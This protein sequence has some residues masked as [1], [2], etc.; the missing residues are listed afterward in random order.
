MKRIIIFLVYVCFAAILSADSKPLA[1][2]NAKVYPMSGPTMD[3]AVVV[4]RDGKIEAIGSGLTAPA[5]ATIIDAKGGRVLPGFVDANCRVGLVEIDAVASTVD[6]SESVD[7]ITPQMRV[8]DAFYPDSATIGVA[9]SNGVTSGIIAP[10]HINVITGMSAWITFSGAS[11]NQVVLKPV[12]GMNITL[13]E[14]PKDTYGS[15]DKMPSTRMGTAA[16]LRENLQAAKEY[17]EK[18]KSYQN[19]QQEGSKKKPVAPPDKDFRLEALLDVVNG[20]VPLVAS[21]QRVDD[22]LTAIRIAEEFGMKQNL[23]INH[24]AEAYKIA[25]LL[26][27]EKIPVIVGPITTQPETMETLGVIY[28]NAALLQKAGVLIALQTNDAHNTRNL[29]YEA[30]FAVANGLPYDEALKAIT[31]NPAKI[32]HFDQEA[33]TLEKGKRAD[34]IVADGDPLEPRTQITHVIIG[35]KEMPDVNYQKRLWDLFLKKETN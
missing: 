5:D 33:G 3:N 26:A 25:D 1:I 27:R 31:I 21:A 9:R 8:T 24:G 10:D 12:A 22:I 23:V 4:I 19:K 32:F 17:G 13:G 18:W 2:V 29:P 28:E 15:K 35:G 34:V 14:P 11:I 20:K 6:S 7:P 30:G 16:L